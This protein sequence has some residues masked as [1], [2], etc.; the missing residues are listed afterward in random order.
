MPIGLG[1]TSINGDIAHPAQPSSVYRLTSIAVFNFIIAL[2]LILPYV[3]ML[4]QWFGSLERR[5]KVSEAEHQSGRAAS[6]QNGRRA[7]SPG[8]RAYASA[9]T[10]SRGPALALAANP[11]V[12]DD[13]S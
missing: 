3:L 2:S 6:E 9:R 12:E 11:Q 4:L 5:F 8:H 7:A 13:E 1:D 10:G